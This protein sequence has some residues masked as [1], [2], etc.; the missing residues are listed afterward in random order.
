MNGRH[1]C[2]ES[3]QLLQVLGG[4]RLANKDLKPMG[5]AGLKQAEL[6]WR[7]W[8]AFCTVQAV[9]WDAAQSA[10]IARFCQTIGPRSSSQ[11]NLARH[12]QCWEVRTKTWTGLCHKSE[13][14]SVFD[15]TEC[16]F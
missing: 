14:V 7:K 1:I 8:L 4:A 16:V 5:P 11:K 2:H 6:I 15:R 13:A 10:G 12:A 3:Q 9:D